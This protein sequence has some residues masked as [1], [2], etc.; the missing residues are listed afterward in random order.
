MSQIKEES[1][2][3]I[4][5][6]N[7]EHGDTTTLV[8]YGFNAE[9]LSRYKRA[10]NAG[11]KE[12][13]NKTIPKVLLLDI[14]TAP[15]EVFT[16][17]L[18]KPVLNYRNIIKRGFMLSWSA[19]WLFSSEMQSDV[20][21]PKEALKQD[22]KRISESIWQL[23]DDADIVIGHNVRKFDIKWL[24]T[25][26]ILNGLKPPMPYQTIDT[27]TEARKHFRFPN[28][29]LDYL[30]QLMTRKQKIETDF[31]LWKRC[32][33]GDKES[34]KYMLEY[35]E[36][37]VLLLEDVYV[38]LRPWIRSHP[39]MGIY[40]NTD[41]PVCDNCGSVNLLW[42]NKYYTTMASKFA[43]FR[44]NECGAPNRCRYTALTREQRK[45]LL[46]STAR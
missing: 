25:E 29:Q 19:K 28:N 30:G 10:Y 4:M 40:M 11:T 8:H 42:E 17:G 16:W 3:E 13:K 33:N 1:L 26:F 9:T 15:M 38:E 43:A 32:V 7:N 12:G 22:D 18:W 6:F 31:G 24:N 23:I 36:Q 37:D 21:T 5:L 41:K 20:V 39:N 45:N 34:L 46:V 27:L 44:C 35:N 14:E 2:T